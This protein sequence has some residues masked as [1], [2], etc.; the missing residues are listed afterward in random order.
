LSKSKVR[1][2]Y[3]T[4]K[5]EAEEWI[6]ALKEVTGV[7]DLTDFY[8]VGKVLGSGQYGIVTEATHK[9]TGQKVAV[10]TCSKEKMNSCELS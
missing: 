7:K 5:S 1:V 4:T 10:K 3:F 8:E 6:K 9:L 2:L